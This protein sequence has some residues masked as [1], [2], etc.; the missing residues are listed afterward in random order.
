V[1]CDGG[2]LLLMVEGR[3]S[4]ALGSFAQA[5][6]EHGGDPTQIQAIAPHGA[7]AI[8]TLRQ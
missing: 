3:S 4:E 2:G 6:R 8:A 1:D 7:E 5:L